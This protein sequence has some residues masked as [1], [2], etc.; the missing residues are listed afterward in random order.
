MLLW[1]QVESS[2]TGQA[3]DRNG[4]WPQGG[5]DGTY[6]EM[7]FCGFGD[8]SPTQ[9]GISLTVN[10]PDASSPTQA[11]THAEETTPTQ[12]TLR[13]EAP[14]F[15]PANTMQPATPHSLTV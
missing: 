4:E 7:C 5:S 3:P 14:P 9:L 15:T 12:S 6:T 11:E 13:K 2:G 10:V 8:W 1:K